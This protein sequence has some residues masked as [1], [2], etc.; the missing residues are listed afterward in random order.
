MIIE[1]LVFV[2][3]YVWGIRYVVMSGYIGMFLY[4]YIYS[5]CF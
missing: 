5:Y 1:V 4:I 2:R 3:Y